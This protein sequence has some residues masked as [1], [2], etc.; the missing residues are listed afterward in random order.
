MSY[1]CLHTILRRIL[2][3]LNENSRSNNSSVQ[4]PQSSIPRSLHTHRSKAATK[5]AHL[6]YGNAPDC[7]NKA[8]PSWC[9]AGYPCINCITFRKEQSKCDAASDSQMAR[10]AG[11]HVYI[12]GERTCIHSVDLNAPC[13]RCGAG[14]TGRSSSDA[15]E[16]SQ[17]APMNVAGITRRFLRGFW[18]Q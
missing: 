18:R 12:D 2:P 7:L 11:S 3:I 8:N 17:L 9:I 10:N 14:D 1:S 6:R 5:S 16:G 15:G 4:L 13:A